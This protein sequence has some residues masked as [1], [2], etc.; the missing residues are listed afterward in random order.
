MART[1]RPGLSHAQKAELWQR[2]KAGETLSDIGRALVK[3]AASVFGVVAAKGGLAPAPRSRKPGSLSLAEREEISRGLA[4]G[5]ALS[6]IGRDLGR[7]AST[8]S[9]EV[10]RNGGRRVYRA[11]R[12]EERALDC[13]LRPKPCRLA[14]NPALCKLVAGKLSGQWSPQQIAGWLKARGHPGD[15][16]MTISH[17]TIYKSLF[18][19]ARGVLKK[20]LLAH[21]RSRRIMRRGRTATT[22]GQT[23]GQIVDAV[24]IRDR[25][26]EVEDRAIPGHWEGDLLSG[27]RNSR[28]ATL[29]ERSSR[30]VML[31]KVGGK[32][33]DSVV[34]ALIFRVQH[35]PQGVMASLTWDRGMELAYHRKF[36]V[37]TDVSVYFCDPKSPWQ[38]GSNENTN[39]LLRQYFPN[40]T[41]LS[42]YTQHD[43]DQVALRLNTRP[44]KTL[45][46]ETPAATFER[47]VALTG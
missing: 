18:I 35:L 25:P 46:F 26:A 24:S 16:S 19:Q 13:A 39:G 33:S 43:L 47:A 15:P 32:D 21:L 4:E 40:G 3:H 38:R 14:F 28:I 31:V 44:R 34:S 7:A 9:R 1:G 11:A 42:V 12:A 23:R 17:E 6:K 5:R 2:W 8:I 10:A 20:E 22:A 36:T 30:F 45:G 37:A 29:V 27:S 41:D